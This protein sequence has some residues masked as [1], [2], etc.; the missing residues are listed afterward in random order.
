MGERTLSRTALKTNCHMVEILKRRTLKRRNDLY[1]L[2]DEPKS[3]NS[4]EAWHRFG[5]I[6]EK[7]HPNI[8]EFISKLQTEQSYTE[9]RVDKLYAVIKKK[10][11]QHQAKSKKIVSD[12]NNY[13]SVIEYLRG[14]S[15]NFYF[16]V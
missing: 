13:P 12:Y 11:L 3:T 10:A 14:C 2:E 15:H 4:L 16:Y 9:C 7:S 8:Y 1:F 5:I 6:I